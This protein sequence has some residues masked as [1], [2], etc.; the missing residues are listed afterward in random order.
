MS[1]A[2][3]ETVIRR[4]LSSP[5]ETGRSLHLG[6]LRSLRQAVAREARQR[7]GLRLDVIGA[8]LDV[9]SDDAIPDVLAADHLLVMLQ[10]R[11]GL[12]GA[13]AIG[14]DLV[15]AL[16]QQQTIGMLMDSDGA[17]PERAFTNTDSALCAPVIEAM[18]AQASE[19]AEAKEDSEAL[20]GHR[21]GQRVRDGRAAA[22]AL[23]GAEFRVIDL[24]L[25]IDQGRAQSR[26]MLILP[27]APAP[28][29][30]EVVERRNRLTLGDVALQAPVRMNAVM[31]RIPLMW[32]DLAEM[33]AGDLLPLPSYRIDRT[34]LLTM[35]GRSIGWGRLGKVDGLRAVRINET[36]S[37]EDGFTEA[38]APQPANPAASP[39]PILSEAVSDITFPPAETIRDLDLDGLDEDTA[40]RRISELAG[41]EDDILQGTTDPTP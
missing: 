9:H 15:R 4:K 39:T 17:A 19:M 40:L 28:P 3:G 16:V 41:L 20:A 33:A 22:V 21:L 23:D 8:T 18:F 10:R 6:L 12:S 31:C 2:Q 5:A 32:S 14:P 35:S 34:E 24:T 27:N 1:G 26:L 25:D 36:T 38:P 37:P 30:E 29:P 7:I 11:A 13:L